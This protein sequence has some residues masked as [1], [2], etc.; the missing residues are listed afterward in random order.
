[1]FKK[2]I[3]ISF[4]QLISYSVIC[5]SQAVKSFTED[6]ERYPEIVAGM[7]TANLS[8]DDKTLISKF[9]DVWNDN[10]F[11]NSEKIEIIR[12]SNEF[13]TK[14]AR[15][16]HYWLFWRCLLS[17]KDPQNLGKGFDEWIKAMIS[18]CHDRRST[19]TSLLALMNSTMDLLNKRLIYS[20][21]GYNWKISN[22]NYRY[23]FDD[24]HLW[25]IVDNFDL[26][27]ISRGDSIVIGQTSGRYLVEEQTW[28][29][30]GGLVTW[31]RADMH[32]DDI[33]ARLGSYDINMK[34]SE[35]EADSAWLTH[36]TYFPTPV[37]GKLIDKVRNISNPNA[38]RYPEFITYNKKFVFEEMYPDVHY[39]GG[40]LIQ[41]SRIIGTGSEDEN[42]TVRIYRQ[43]DT[44]W[45]NVKSK[46]FVFTKDRINSRHVQLAIHF[47]GDSIYHNKLA[48]TYLV[49]N[50][51]VNLF[52][53]DEATSM[54]PYLN[55]YHRISLNFEQIIWKTDEKRMNFSMARGSTFGRASFRSQNYFDQRYFDGLQFRDAVHPLISIRNTAARHG[56]T[57]S[58]KAY[59][60]QIK[61]SLSDARVQ[62]ITIAKHGFILFDSERDVAIVQPHLYEAINAA[63]KRID[64]DVIEL[65]SQVNSPTQNATFDI[66][67]HDLAING[68]ERFMVS[69][70]QRV[71]ISPKGGEVKMR[72]NR[73]MDIDGRINAGR[74]EFFGQLMRFDYDNF[75]IE[76]RKVDVLYFYVPTGEIDMMGRPIQR[77]LTTP[78]KKIRGNILID[79]PDNKSGR[80]SLK[81]YPILSSDSISTVDYDSPDIE[82]GAYKSETFHFAIDPFVRDSLDRINKA[83]LALKGLFISGGIF[84]DMRQTLRVQPDYSLGFVHEADSALPTY[85]QSD[86]YAQVRLSNKGL[87]ASG[88]L[89]YLTTSIHADDFK[90]YP[91]SMNVL[92][93]K[94]LNMRKQKTGI[95]FPALNAKGS[96]IHWTPK[97]E[98]MHIFNKN[99][100]MYNGEAKLDGSLLLKPTGLQGKGKIDVKNETAEIGSNDFSFKADKFSAEQSNL[101]L[102]AVKDGPYRVMTIDSI[103][104]EI[105][106]ESRK[107][108]F[109]PNNRKNYT[110]VDFPSNKYAGFVEKMVWDM[111]DAILNITSVD[112]LAK[113]VDFKYAYPG[114]SKGSRYYSTT[115]G[116]D[117][118]SFVAPRATLDLTSG[119]INAEGVNLVKTFDAIVYPGEKKLSVN[120]NGE[121]ELVESKIVFNDRMKQH[122]VYDAT[123]KMQGRRQFFGFGKYDYIDETGKAQ[124]IE[125]E[126]V[127]TDR[128][129][130]TFATGVIPPESKFTLSP[131]FRYQGNMLLSS[132]NT[133]P[134][135]DGVSQIVH[136]C[137][138]LQTEWFKINTP[139][140]PDSIVFKIADEPVNQFGSRLYN[141]LFVTNDSIY[142][143]FFTIRKTP[144]DRQMVHASGILTYNK[145]SMTYFLAPVRKL[146]NRDTVGNL[147]ALNRDKCLLS[148]EGKLSFGVNFGRVKHEVVGRMTHNINNHETTF[149]VMMSFDFLFDNT[150]AGMI[151]TGIKETEWLAG[152]DMQRQ[153]YI[154]GMNELLG[155]AKS[156]TYRR[157]A[158]LGDVQN[159]PPELNKTIVLSQ[160]NMYW[161]HSTRSYR[162]TGRIGVSNLFGHQVNRLVEGMVEITK[163]STGDMFDIYLRMD[164][165]NWYY[166][167]YTR[168]QLQVI[169]SDKAFNERLVK[170]PDK[171][172]RQTDGRPR[173]TYMIATN[174]K[175][176]TFLRQY[177]QRATQAPPSAIQDTNRQPQPQPQP[178][179]VTSPED[180]T[181]IVEIE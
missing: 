6:P 82:K 115:K 23:L 14:R 35:Y 143:A 63:A 172:R 48:F 113:P 170:M 65:N 128:I 56:T 72:K 159:F 86:L 75:D 123:L 77:R 116:A 84:D 96:R 20:S 55:T 160:V 67:T 34:R 1:M 122:T 133:Y 171:Q 138:S 87:Q 3:I 28:K 31:E 26:V 137:K 7:F 94:E 156:E 179:P 167:G 107:G 52:R 88:R 61:T 150:L 90:L 57:F 79:H 162:S 8:V 106:F 152:V 120:T 54:A 157:D 51:E 181:P 108:T 101:Q 74:A 147:I 124:V 25:V 173:F 40:I 127:L 2:V 38:A 44:L 161:D 12:I 139:I 66:R 110:L 27:C 146:L 117:S 43:G 98:T 21:A 163:R 18:T 60:E 176:E 53:T 36:K 104:S 144:G 24:E 37:M 50:R 78:I 71:I 136:E 102:R 131:F 92:N 49:D 45:M 105:D 58:S 19:P 70:S 168:E 41:G 155:V 33:S 62:L 109:V 154:R 134:V 126:K 135:F 119:V 13:I 80:K 166:F 83:T 17:F 165:N 69:D 68:I 175:L 32:R 140:Q 99:F 15:N 145:D 81:Y 4:I 93:A 100:D 85:K 9:T 174:T 76:L 125:I 151:A 30:N 149:N 148:A 177:R 132:D 16:I 129:G 59:S 178:Q 114:E 111:D 73:G 10:T 130:K 42:A 11:D 121:L 39:E 29:G 180:N 103:R 89:E 118:L 22:H 46:G 95:E 112:T 142:P 169:S 158:L 91:D 97:K 141:G 164:D 153:S 64:F 5:Y 47:F